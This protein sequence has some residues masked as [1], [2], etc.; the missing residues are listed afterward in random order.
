MWPS[1]SEPLSFL[2][3]QLLPT[4]DIYTWTEE[5]V[6]S[7]NLS[8]LIYLRVFL[9]ALSIE[10]TRCHLFG[11]LF[12]QYFWMQQI[13]GAGEQLSS[14]KSFHHF[15]L[16]APLLCFSSWSPEE[17]L[18]IINQTQLISRKQHI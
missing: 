11:F 4:L 8:P 6:V 9:A 12:P 1:R 15:T 2:Y 16:K 17:Q 10:L 5:H 18:H 13:F 14:V 7:I 3:T